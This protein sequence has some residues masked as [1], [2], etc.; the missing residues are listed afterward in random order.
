MSVREM[1]TLSP[2]RERATQLTGR[3]SECEALDRLVEAVRAGE[4]RALVVRGEPGVGKSALLDYVVEQA[5]GCRVVRAVGVQSE[6]ELAFAG[7]H[8]LLAPLL[9]GVERLPGPQRDALRT[10]F[11]VSPG[12]APD[13]FLTALAVLSLLSD[14]AEEQPLL[15]LVDDEQWLDRASTQVLAF[16]AR[17]L[18]A[19]SVA[20]IFAARTPS[21][22]LAGLPELV[23]E[24][25]RAE[26][27][28]ALLDAVLSAPLDGRVRDQI[29]SETRGNPLA[30]L[31][32][33]RE[34]TPAEL[35]GGF[36]LPGGRPHSG[37]TEERFERRLAA[38]PAES[39]RLLLLAAA[40]PVGDPLLVWRAAERLGIPPEAATPAADAGLLDIGGR[41]RFRHP[42]VRSAAYRSASVQERQDVH[43][44]LAEVTDAAADPD[45]RA[46][47]RAHA[48]PGPD[49]DVAVELEGSADRAQ[50]RGGL[51]A[52]AAFLERAVELTVDPAHLAC[53]AF[54]AAQA[55]QLAGASD[56][57]LALLA[58]AEAGPLSEAQRAGADMLRGQ[59]AFASSRG[60][61]VPP[62]LLHAAER[63]EPLDAGLARATYLDALGAATFAGRLASPGG[64]VLD[65][66]LA[67][68][69]VAPPTDPPRAPDLLLDGL[70]ANF[71]DGYAAAAPIL[72]RAL[73]SFG[74]AMSPEEELRWLWTASITALHLWDDDSWHALS[75]RHVQLARASGALSELPLALT[76]RIYA[77]L[78]AGELTAA[79]SLTEEVQAVTEATGIQLTPFGALGLAAL[80]GR[81]AEASALIETSKQ[82]VQLRGQGI[83][84]TIASWA[85]AVLHNSLGHYQQ[86]LTAAREATEYVPDMG[87]SY[88]ALGELVEAAVR[89]GEREPAVAAHQRLLAVT[90]VSGTDWALGV[91]ARAH[92][93]LSEGE[94][95][96]LLYREAVERLGRTRLR[97]ELARAQLLYGE[98]LRRE[99]R[100]VDAREQL[101]TA[102]EL[103]ASMGA[104]AFA[105][106]AGR[107]LLA[108]G[109][110]VRKRTV[111]TRGDLTAQEAQIARLARDGLS[112]PEIGARLF[113]SPRTVQYH[114]RKVFLKLG[115]RSRSQLDR[116]LPGEPAADWLRSSKRGIV[117]REAVQTE[118]T[119]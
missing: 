106:R 91:E 4:S 44:A 80:Q 11:G 95:A 22:H 10:V 111:E 8:Q 35:A 21:D 118:R 113:I 24:S 2:V 94:A 71:T 3:R 50:A 59:I 47:H 100:R 89:S 61:D 60:S 96:E 25:L 1:A 79:A 40:D 48:A 46:W 15:C 74:A 32:L 92:A 13:R 16:V 37:S 28:H 49:E 52:A 20:L 115:I 56:A 65:V 84:I 30:L 58:R 34:L 81:Q 83:G 19:E 64:G 90:A 27:A 97:L 108:T 63:L 41:V 82:D 62:L 5:A 38:L 6:M 87:S 23:V 9:D 104:E 72:R 102:H 29:V 36:A 70:A 116:V 98:W 93:L 17:R 112:N 109:E 119:T 39:R 107:E 12:P 85:S 73:S 31:E 43:R 54:N 103:F 26:D 18:E 53:R 57:A 67:A 14:V 68:R 33:I 88:W 99:S 117:Q 101:R 114:L 42:L 77:H 76:S 110:T 7:L 66:A 105:D 45:R 75:S 69:A 78:L 55:K 86:A 51:A